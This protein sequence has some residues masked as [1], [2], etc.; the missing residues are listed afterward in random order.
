ML[1]SENRILLKKIYE[2]LED[3]SLFRINIVPFSMDAVDAFYDTHADIVILDTSVFLSF[4]NIL[5]QIYQ[6]NWPF[7]VLLIFH[8]PSLVYPKKENVYFAHK[9]TISRELF[10][11]IIANIKEHSFSLKNLNTCITFNWNGKHSVLINPDSYHIL[12]I[13]TFDE[14]HFLDITSCNNLITKALPFCNLHLIHTSD[15]IA[16][17][18]MNRSQIKKEFNFT[19]LSSIV[20]DI[21]G[22]QTALFYKENIS[23]KKLQPLLAEIVDNIPLLYFL[24]GESKSFETLQHPASSPALNA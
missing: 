5:E 13:K 7:H 4:E 1:I 16:I 15:S 8:E 12:V 17:F 19:L 14:N 24:Q 11:E 2:M 6:Y 9:D 21:L 22:Q 3:P 20:F 23:W 18:Y 10:H